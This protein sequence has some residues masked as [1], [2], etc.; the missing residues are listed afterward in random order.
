MSLKDTYVTVSEAAEKLGVT[1]Q[2]IYR[3]VKRGLMDSE[4]IGRE[5]LIK[6]KDL[7]KLRLTK[8]VETFD[9]AIINGFIH[10]LRQ[11]YELSSEDKIKHLGNLMFDVRKADGSHEV[12]SIIVFEIKAKKVVWMPYEEF[13]KKEGTSRKL[14]RQK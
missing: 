5:T 11:D 13:K 2:T 3:W 12:A 8:V 7:H 14:S 4:K 1:R 10:D 9:E 6:K